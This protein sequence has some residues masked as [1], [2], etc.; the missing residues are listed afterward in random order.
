[1]RFTFKK[2][3]PKPNDMRI[4]KRFLWWPKTIGGVIRWLETAIW[5]ER[6]WYIPYVN[7][8]G[9]SYEWTESHWYG[10]GIDDNRLKES[11]PK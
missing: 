9:G 5:V 6:Y 2:Q 3:N 7:E 10:E 8:Q 4:R 1:M 11:E